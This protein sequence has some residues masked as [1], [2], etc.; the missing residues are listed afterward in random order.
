MNPKVLLYNT[1]VSAQIPC[2]VGQDIWIRTFDSISLYNCTIKNFF[3]RVVNI[4][5][6]F[7]SHSK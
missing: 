6:F 5:N 2:I 7:N 3:L 4:L 1:A